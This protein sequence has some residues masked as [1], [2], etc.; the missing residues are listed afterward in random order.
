MRAIILF[1]HGSVLCGAGENLFAMARTMEARGDAPVVEVGFLNYS[2]PTF[3]EAFARC[4]ERGADQITV[5]PYFLVAGYF[6]GV[7]LP[8]KVEAMRAQFPDVEVVTA[9]AL[10]TH[11]LLAQAITNCAQRAQAPEKWRDIL[12]EAP[13]FCLDNPQC[14][15]NGTPKCPL[16]PTPRAE[17]EVSL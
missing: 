11:E 15:L 10:K 13:Q 12:D 9:Q 16:R 8:P 6:V 14:P 3:E 1:S 2:R 7:A 5:A 17:A 4:V